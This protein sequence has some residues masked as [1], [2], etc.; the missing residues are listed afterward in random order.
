MRAFL[1]LKSAEFPGIPGGERR[2]VALSPAS[3]GAHLDLQGRSSQKRA[4]RRVGVVPLGGG[5]FW[6]VT[7][8]K[9]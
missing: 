6:G 1:V 8:D 9:V 4:N 2:S 3:E 5:G 7:S